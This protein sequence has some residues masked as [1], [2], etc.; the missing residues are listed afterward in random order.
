VELGW[1]W[2]RKCQSFLQEY[3]S[4]EYF[5]CRGEEISNYVWRPIDFSLW[6]YLALYRLGTLLE[7]QL[8]RPAH[9]W[10]LTKLQG[11]YNYYGDAIKFL[12]D[13]NRTWTVRVSLQIS[14]YLA[15]E[16]HCGASERA[17]SFAY[18][19]CSLINGSLK[20]R[21]ESI[22]IREITWAVS[23]FL[24]AFSDLTFSNRAP[25]AKRFFFGDEWW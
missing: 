15:N 3:F 16:K 13:D 20:S 1:L 10:L 14:F 17:I 6:V 4:G 8:A 12:N 5:S 24:R 22:A 9:L 23:V 2:Y 18:A 7:R 21:Y 19:N 25:N 11:R